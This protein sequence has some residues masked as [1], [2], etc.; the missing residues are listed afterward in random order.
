MIALGGVA[1]NAGG[2]IALGGAVG[3]VASIASLVRNALVQGRKALEGVALGAGRGLFDALW[4]MRPMAGLTALLA[5][6]NLGL[7]GV[8]GRASRARASATIVGIVAAPA[9][10][11][12]SR[13]G[14]MLL[15]MTVV[16]ALQEGHGLVGGMAFLTIRVTA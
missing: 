15:L 10:L 7:G 8:A 4:T 3:A 6:A 11:V 9:I 14:G 1:L 5:M 2:P 13:C 12:S 16:A